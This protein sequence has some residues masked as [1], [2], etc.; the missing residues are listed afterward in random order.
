MIKTKAKDKKNQSPP[1]Y[2]INFIIDF[3]DDHIINTTNYIDITTSQLII[4][5]V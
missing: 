4:K 3:S 2:E 1:I 5:N